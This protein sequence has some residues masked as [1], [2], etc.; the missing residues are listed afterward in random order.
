MHPANR[1]KPTHHTMTGII[2][3][4]TATTAIMPDN[5]RLSLLSTSRTVIGATI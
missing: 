1:G 5:C 4:A 2:T 3:I